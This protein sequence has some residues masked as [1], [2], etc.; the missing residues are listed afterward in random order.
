MV[1]KCRTLDSLQ[2]GSNPA[3]SIRVSYFDKITTTKGASQLD[4]FP[5]KMLNLKITILS[6]VIATSFL[7]AKL[8]VSYKSN[9]AVKPWRYKLFDVTSQPL[10]PPCSTHPFSV[11]LPCPIPY[12]IASASQRTIYSRIRN[13]SFPSNATT[14]WTKYRIGDLFKL[15]TF[16]KR[17]NASY[18]RNFKSSLGTEYIDRVDNPFNGSSSKNFTALIQIIKDRIERNK[19]LQSMLPDDKT[20]VIHL[21]TGDVIDVHNVSIHQFLDHPTK[22]PING[23]KICPCAILLC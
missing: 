14:P 16:R 4:P 19:T 5:I 13:L 9:Q 8:F 22:D 2:I 7:S 10:Q 21:R 17:N 6:F 1:V 18:H 12:P 20:L 3:F 23:V 15:W 11:Q